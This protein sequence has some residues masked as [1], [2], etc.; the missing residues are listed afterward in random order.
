VKDFTAS[1][2][3]M[4]ESPLEDECGKAVTLQLGQLD[5]I[6]TEPENA[7]VNILHY[8]LFSIALF[9]YEFSYKGANLLVENLNPIFHQIK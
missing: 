9:Y 4:R 5:K 6:K 2:T 3:K 1:D 7:Q 8:F